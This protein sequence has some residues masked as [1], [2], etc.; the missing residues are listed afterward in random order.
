[1]GAADRARARLVDGMRAVVRDAA[2]RG[3]GRLFDPAI[4]E[5]FRAV[6]RHLFLPGVPIARA[7]AD[8]AV[9]VQAVDGV[10]TSSAS[11]PSMMA[12]MLGQLDL[13]PGHRV[14]EVGAGTGY[15]AALMRRLVGPSG[16]VVAVDIDGELVDGAAQHL[17]D[18]GV[19]GVEL[20]CADGAL[21]YP[22]GAPYD[23]I[24]LTV[25]SGDVRPEWVAQ[26]APGGRLLLPLAVRGT[27]LSVALDLCPDG[28]L[29]SDSVNRCAFVRLRGVG[30]HRE[31]G[32][33]LDGL[34]VLP[35]DDRGF[36]PEAVEAALAAPGGSRPAPLRLGPTDQWD[37]FGLWLALAEP[38]T[39]RLLAVGGDPD[40]LEPSG[41]A[42]Q[43]GLGPGR[44]TVGLLVDGPEG[45]GLATVAVDRTGDERGPWPVQLRTF[46][47]AAE[48]A[49]DRLLA[50][51][52]TWRAAGRPT[53]ADLRLT[54][55]PRAATAP[56]PPGAAV[57][58]KEHC[59]IVVDVPAP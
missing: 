3:D 33:A 26:L 36:R 1:M 44:G 6:P 7:Y 50:A 27:Q 9:A 47:P 38:G 51:A 35:A 5:A 28:L 17:A 15:N 21:G 59:R 54:V 39:C 37:G 14:L 57:V 55:V 32:L 41:A 2:G 48:E 10:T 58:E 34:S 42:A 40:D 25:G 56:A 12:I 16:R 53:A 8:E 22:P 45:P 52:A 24:V 13:Q 23:R 11:Q 43:L 20:H 46:G 49:A 4:E 29:R 19:A 31:P 30:A 18:A